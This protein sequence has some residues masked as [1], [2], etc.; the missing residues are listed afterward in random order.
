MPVDWFEIDAVGKLAPARD[1]PP[2]FG[3]DAIR[4]PLYATAAR[5]L[6]L[7]ETVLAWWNTVAQNGKPIPAWIDVMSGETAPFPLSVGGM[8][9]VGR[10]MGIAQPEGLAEDYYSAILQLLAHDI[11]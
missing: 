5:R 2:R 4:V 9:V 6:S 3:F 11:V 1:K 8:A 7:A 10:A